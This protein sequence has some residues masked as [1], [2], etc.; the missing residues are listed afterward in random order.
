MKEE[1]E[2]GKREGGIERMKKEWKNRRKVENNV[3][4]V[5]TL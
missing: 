3:H 5:N 2:E 4:R 1:R